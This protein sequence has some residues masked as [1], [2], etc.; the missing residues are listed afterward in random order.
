MLFLKKIPHT[1][2][3]LFF[4]FLLNTTYPSISAQVHILHSFELLPIPQHILPAPGHHLSCFPPFAATHGAALNILGQKILLLSCLRVAF[5][6]ERT[7]APP[8]WPRHKGW[9]SCAPASG[10]Q[11]ARTWQTLTFCFHV[12]TLTLSEPMSPRHQAPP[13]HFPRSYGVPAT[14]SV[15]SDSALG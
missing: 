3:F 4:F 7:P 2:L 12:P 10:R 9:S 11:G 5:L 1:Y 6:D 15:S 8:F 14:D 13:W